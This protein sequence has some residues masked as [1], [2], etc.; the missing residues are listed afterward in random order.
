M[1]RYIR[2]VEMIDRTLPALAPLFDEMRDR[3]RDEHG[4]TKARYNHAVPLAVGARLAVSAS[5]PIRALAEDY[6]RN[7]RHELDFA[8]LPKMRLA[9]PTRWVDEPRDAG[10]PRSVL[11]PREAWRAL[12]RKTIG[13]NW[14]HGFDVPV[15]GPGCRRGLFKINAPLEQP[16]SDRYMRGV[17]YVV[18]DFHL[19]FCAVELATA[20]QIRLAPGDQEALAGAA[21]GLKAEAIGYELGITGRAVEE[22]LANARKTLGCKTTAEAVAKAVTLGLIL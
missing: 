12:V 5:P 16:I 3:L 8:L 6:I 10:C 21:A 1:N 14:R 11:P 20:P 19:A 13:E 9:E 15:Y 18:Q 17:R 2:S 7:R 22:R 4:V